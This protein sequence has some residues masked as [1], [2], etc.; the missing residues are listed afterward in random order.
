MAQN[1]ISALRRGAQDSTLKTGRG[2]AGHSP[3]ANIYYGAQNGHYM[4][5]AGKN[6][7]D[8]FEEW[9]SSGVYAPMQLVPIALA[10]PLVFDAMPERDYFIGAY[11]AMIE[12]LPQSIEGFAAGLTVEHTSKPVGGSEEVIEEVANVTRAK[13]DLTMNFVEVPGRGI[14]KFLNAWNRMG[15]MDPE[16]KV[17]IASTAGYL[18]NR[19]VDDLYTPDW[20]TGAAIYIEPDR[21]M[22]HVSDA[23]LL[24]NIGPKSD[25]E[26]VGKRD[27]R[28]ALESREYS[29]Q[30]TSLA[31]H[32]DCYEVIDLAKRLFN[33]LTV[34][35]KVSDYNIVA[36][37]FGKEDKDEMIISPNLQTAKGGIN[38]EIPNMN[39]SDY[40][41]AGERGTVEDLATSHLKGK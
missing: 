20:Y 12:A 19:F 41:N 37:R 38:D 1:D 13:T 39:P 40:P 15:M 29:I 2:Y 31:M 6:G 33:T 18:G 36:P 27:K 14:Q 22:Q 7:S 10:Y 26:R 17:P 24:V 9:I 23:W 25:G 16:T 28:A 8:Y 3:T 11:K 32:G 21:T 4:R 34:F 5:V 35:K 30:F